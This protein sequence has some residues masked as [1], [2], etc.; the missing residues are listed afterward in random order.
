MKRR[1][2]LGTAAS[3][4]GAA[5]LS[6][7]LA[8]N[9]D[10]GGADDLSDTAT[11]TPTPTATSAP[12]STADAP[13]TTTDR[14]DDTTT[15]YYPTDEPNPDHSV[16][17]DNYHDETHTLSV[18]VTRE[19]GDVVHDATHEFEPGASTEIYNLRQASPDGIES[20]TIE[21]TMGDQQTSVTIETSACYGSALISITEDGD[22][23]S[24]YSIC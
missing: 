14:G 24:T 11:T 19:S 18:T 13:G 5:L 1:A 22:L 21:V 15:D 7:C 2:F 17:V 9:Q 16:Y 6:G 8:E 10:V 23:D 4:V 3:A 20:F 12:G